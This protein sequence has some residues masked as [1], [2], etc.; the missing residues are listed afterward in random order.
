MDDKL[1]ADISKIFPT[2]AY[3][4]LRYANKLYEEA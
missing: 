1:K 4:N 2:F 3:R